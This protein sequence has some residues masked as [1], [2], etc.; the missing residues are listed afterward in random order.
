MRLFLCVLVFSL[1][2]CKN[3]VPHKVSLNEMVFKD[4]V[5]G[6]IFVKSF[7]DLELPIIGEDRNTIIE[8]YIDPNRNYDTIVA[9][10]NC[11]PNNVRRLISLKKYKE[12]NVYIYCPP[13]LRKRFSQ[14]I[15]LE[16][17]TPLISVSLKPLEDEFECI[18]S[19]LFVLNNHRFNPIE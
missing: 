7:N 15:D 16:D 8:F 2:G 14:L 1:I 3:E 9:I 13:N 5:F 4:S 10:R 11:P 17:D 6:N 19:R 12:S 18:Y